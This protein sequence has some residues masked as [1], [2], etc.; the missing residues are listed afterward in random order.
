MIFYLCV[1]TCAHACGGCGY[2]HAT[3]LVRRSEDNLYE[4]VLSLP[5]HGS[6]VSDQITRLCARVLPGKQSHAAQD[7]ISIIHL[8]PMGP[9][10]VPF[11]FCLF[12]CSCLCIMCVWMCGRPE[13]CIRCLPQLPHL[14]Q[15]P[16]WP[17]AHWVFWADWLISLKDLLLC[18]SPVLGTHTHT[19]GHTGF[20]VYARFQTQVPL[21]SQQTLYWHSLLVDAFFKVFGRHVIFLSC[22]KYSKCDIYFPFAS[23]FCMASFLILTQSHPGHWL[24]R[25]STFLKKIY[26]T[27]YNCQHHRGIT[28]MLEPTTFWLDLGPASQKG[29]HAWSFS[30]D[31]NPR[32]WE[33]IALGGTLLLL[34]C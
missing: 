12:V 23:Q 20:Y 11:I 34:F 19:H 9:N 3:A 22:T 1:C 14:R 24:P 16:H 5:P 15:I 7:D 32:T 13:I 31:Q 17:G 33:G 21:L 10:A 6:Q 29:I 27:R 8:F 28:I 2:V 18:I 26:A 4:S 30:P 25:N